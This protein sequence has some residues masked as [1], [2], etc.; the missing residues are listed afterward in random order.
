M[1]LSSQSLL[2]NEIMARPQ[3]GGSEYIEFVNVSDEEVRLDSYSIAIL[4]Q[5]GK[6]SRKYKFPPQ[7]VAMPGQYLLI[8]PDSADII[9][10]YPFVDISSLVQF[11][12]WPRLNDRFCTV[13][14]IKHSDGKDVIAD[15]A[16]H[17]V[18]L[19][20]YGK[21]SS[22]GIALEKLSPT[23]LSD[24]VSNWSIAMPPFYASPTCK[25]TVVS[26][27]N[28]SEDNENDGGKVDEPS[29]S[30]I[31][32]EDVESSESDEPDNELVLFSPL[33][34][35]E[36][37]L[38]SKK[39][40]LS[41]VYRLD[42]AKVKRFNDKETR[43][44]ARGIISGDNFVSMMSLTPGVYFLYLSIKDYSRMKSL[45]MIEPKR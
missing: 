7:S 20:P 19:Y 28:C 17:S 32:G 23:L 37:A 42:G 41:I 25:N 12:E 9:E 8:C 1:S 33:E 26:S 13:L 38:C 21:K 43:A 3:K 10:R 40:V 6:A 34:L 31:E 36:E 45:I 22:Y 15:R 11:D 2:F 4:R 24:D 30:E 27:D 14:L 16:T 39:P 44:W 29:N 35:A 18:S 5:S